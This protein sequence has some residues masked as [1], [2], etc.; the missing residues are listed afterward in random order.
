MHPTAKALYNP[1]PPPLTNF[2]VPESENSPNR[3]RRFLSFIGNSRAGGPL[4]TPDHGP[5]CTHRF[6]TSFLIPDRRNPNIPPTDH[7][8][9]HYSALDK[10]ATLSTGANTTGCPYFGAAVD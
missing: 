7:T 9:K 10:A 3:G 5:R 1:K 4:F 6:R 2:L 8:I